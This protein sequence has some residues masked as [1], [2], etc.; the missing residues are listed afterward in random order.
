MLSL[1]KSKL[2]SLIRNGIG[3]TGDYPDWHSAQAKCSGYDTAIILEKVK[4]ATLK[5]KFGEAAHERDSVV[6]DKIEYS[7]PLLSALMFVSLRN[8]ARLSV[9]DFGGS[10]GSSYFQNRKFL[11]AVQKLHWTVVE[12]ASFVK[13]GVKFIQDDVLDFQLTMQDALAQRPYDLFVISCA[14]QYMQKPYELIDEICSQNIPFLIVDNTPFN[15][16]NR[17]RITIQKV[18]PAIYTASYPCWFL[19]YSSVLKRFATT[20]QIIAEFTNDTSIELDGR[21]VPYQ[22]FLLEL[23]KQ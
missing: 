11:A 4:E 12:Q 20:Y 9:L 2:K 3:W 8:S 5:V 17:D 14:L 18:P 19:D 1:L 21:K 23:K 13:T 6:F 22:G 10:L 16:V 7:F 15:Y